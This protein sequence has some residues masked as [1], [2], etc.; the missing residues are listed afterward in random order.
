MAK[1][2]ISVASRQYQPGTRTVVLPDLT[3]D[4]SGIKVTLTREGWPA[5]DDI[6]LGVIESSNGGAVWL[7][8]ARVIYAGGVQLDPRTGQVV[9]TCGPSIY[10]PERKIDGFLIPQRPAQVRITVTNTVRLTTAISLTGL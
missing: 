3:A 8:M 2:S 10:W 7:E 4:D 6:I 1:A 5:G 9:D